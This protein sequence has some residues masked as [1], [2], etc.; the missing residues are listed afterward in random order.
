MKSDILELINRT[1]FLLVILLIIF[2]AVISVTCEIVNNYSNILDVTFYCA[3]LISFR[4]DFTYKRCYLY[5]A[6]FH[7]ID[8]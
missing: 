5:L 2:Y 1:I 3:P 8:C 7:K 6:W 4:S